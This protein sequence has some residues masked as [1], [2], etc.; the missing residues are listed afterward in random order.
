MRGLLK[1]T[2]QHCEH[3]GTGCCVRDP[4]P[5][6][7]LTRKPPSS[8]WEHPVKERW[9]LIMMLS[10][11]ACE[12]GVLWA[13]LLNQA[14]VEGREGG[15]KKRREEMPSSPLVIRCCVMAIDYSNHRAVTETQHW[16]NGYISST[17]FQI[18]PDGWL[19]EFTMSYNCSEP[20]NQLVSLFIV[21]SIVPRMLEDSWCSHYT[22]WE[23]KSVKVWTHIV[24][25]GYQAATPH[26]TWLWP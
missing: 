12:D 8:D 1:R 13:I 3:K 6:L 18:S 19:W 10:W 16:L 11:V 23:K 24:R 25:Q 4:E 2:L 20:G 14:G 9:H 21:R 22:L 7:A 15:R 17:S 26:F 5:Q